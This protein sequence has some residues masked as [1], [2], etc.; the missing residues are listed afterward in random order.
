MGKKYSTKFNLKPINVKP[1]IIRKTVELRK[2]DVDWFEE[3]YSGV[4]NNASISWVLSLMLEHFRE[5]HEHSPTDYARMGAE[6]LKRRLE[7][8]T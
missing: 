7:D 6:E 2:E 1:D 5:V 3:T 8:E 4:T